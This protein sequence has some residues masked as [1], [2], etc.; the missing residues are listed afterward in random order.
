[1]RFVSIAAILMGL[2]VACAPARTGSAHGACTGSSRVSR[3]SDAERRHEAED[4]HGDHPAPCTARVHPVAGARPGL[5]SEG[6][7][8]RRNRRGA[9][10][11]F[12]HRRDALGRRRR[13][14][15]QLRRRHPLDGQQRPRDAD[16]QLVQRPQLLHDRGQEQYRLRSGVDRQVVRGFSRRWPGPRAVDQSSGRQGCARRLRELRQ[17]RRAEHSR[18]GAGGQSGRCDDCLAGHLG[19]R[20]DRNEHQDPGRRRRLLQRGAAGEQGQCGDHK[21]A[22]REARSAAPLYG[23]DHQGQPLLCREQTGLGRRDGQAAA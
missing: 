2:L 23:G 19:D 9:G 10:H 21:S 15:H 4:R 1:M 3:G 7:S 13:R 20:A 11:T 8:R 12:G 17:H 16:D 18:P 22:G 14:Q 6:R 5:L